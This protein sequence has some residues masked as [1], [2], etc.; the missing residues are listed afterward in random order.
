MF[1]SHWQFHQRHQSRQPSL[2]LSLSPYL[3]C[4]FCPLF[5][6]LYQLYDAAL[7]F[8]SQD[9]PGAYVAKVAKLHIV[10]LAGLY[11]YCCRVI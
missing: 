9:F 11:L 10:T 4:L 7:R 6:T 2:V 8:D 1:K 3:F 5:G